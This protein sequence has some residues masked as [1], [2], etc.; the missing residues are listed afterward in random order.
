MSIAEKL[1]LIN[2]YYRN[3]RSAVYTRTNV[4]PNNIGTIPNQIVSINGANGY[5]PQQITPQ[6]GII[7]KA[8]YIASVTNE[9]KT[10]IVRSGVNVSR[11]S[12]FAQGIL[13]IT[14]STVSHTLTI[15]GLDNA[16]GETVQYSVLF[17]DEPKTS[18]VTWQITSGDSYAT[19]NNTG[20]LTI[21]SSANNNSVTINASYNGVSDSKTILVTYQSGTSSATEI[22]TVTN[23]DG[24][25]SQTVIT[26]TT[27]QDGSS[28]STSNT[29]NYDSNGNVIGTAQNET[30]TNAD[31]SSNSVTTNYDANG[32]ETGHV[33]A[34]GDTEGNTKTQTVEKDA[35]GNDVVTSYDITTN[36]NTGVM[37]SEEFI[38][39][40]FIPF[41]GSSDWTL[42][43]KFRWDWERNTEERSTTTS[44]LSCAEFV[45]G[46]MKSG[47]VLRFYAA[48]A[49]SSTTTPKTRPQLQVSVNDTSTTKLL[50]V[51]GNSGRVYTNPATYDVHITK[52]GNTI[53]FEIQAIGSLKY[54]PTRDSTS[55]SRGCK[56]T[57]NEIVTYSW[58]DNSTST[59]DITIGG[60]L[61]S[62]GQ[63]AQKSDIDVY[64]FNV[65]KI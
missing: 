61:N 59:V 23:D 45:S 16:I 15:N 51:T 17:D 47:F 24:T 21:D 35:N 5:V 55:T 27:N 62:Q 4:N 18:G 28:S 29:T 63:L 11:L 42:N 20:L 56:T 31:G 40:G 22:E 26:T 33:S 14:Q 9:I 60:Y 2:Q 58:T 49:T 53:N 38:E 8:N 12:Q 48:K 39:T 6:P 3:I 64:E 19:I 57:Q 13:D 43:F 37:K 32:N 54:N 41:D 44:V 65:Q 25:T 30:I 1:L 46:Q 52:T 34:S 7:G 50:F 36:E 10:C